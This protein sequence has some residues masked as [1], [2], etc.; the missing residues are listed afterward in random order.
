VV[1]DHLIVGHVP[2]VDGAKQVRY[3]TLVSELTLSGDITS[4]P[5]THTVYFAGEVP[6]DHL[7]APLS[8]LVVD[9]QPALHVTAELVAE[10]MFSSKPTPSGVYVDYYEKLTTYT[11]ILSSQAQAIDPDATAHL[12]TRP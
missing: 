6:C 1:G 8:K 5:S 3:G 2:Y 9:G 11:T 4:R 10:H 7:G 12:P